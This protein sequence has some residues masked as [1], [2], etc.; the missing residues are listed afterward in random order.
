MGFLIFTCQTPSG[1]LI[2]HFNVFSQVFTNSGM[3]YIRLSPRWLPENDQENVQNFT[4][5]ANI[6]GA[7]VL[8]CTK[9]P[10]ID[11]TWFRDTP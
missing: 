11:V 7:H 5:F 3:S 4:F 10:T 9:T 1:S 2:L 6:L 8:F